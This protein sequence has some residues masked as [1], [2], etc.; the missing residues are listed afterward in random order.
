MIKIIQEPTLMVNPG[1]VPNEQVLAWARRVKAKRTQTK[2]L[3]SLKQTQDFDAI[4]S[5]KTGPKVKQTT[6]KK[7]KKKIRVHTNQAKVKVLQFQ[8][9]TLI[10]SSLWE[11][12]YQME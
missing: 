11:D 5:Q 9:P 2:M 8:P 12:V 3:D 1:S 4:G 7:K 6:P 10:V